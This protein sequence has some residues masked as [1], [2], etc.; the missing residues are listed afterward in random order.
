MLWLV[1]NKSDITLVMIKS[2]EF[3]LKNFC[4]PNINWKNFRRCFISYI[5]IKKERKKKTDKDTCH[6]CHLSEEHYCLWTK[7]S[8]QEVPHFICRTSKHLSQV[9]VVSSFCTFCTVYLLSQR[10]G[11]RL[12]QPE[13]KNEVNRVCV[14]AKY[15][16][17]FELFI[18]PKG[19]K[20][21]P[22][23][24]VTWRFKRES[25]CQRKQRDRVQNRV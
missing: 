1:S 13:Y 24:A 18:R 21:W 2:W 23:K 10:E 8:K 22:K 11:E 16:I 6:C 20:S 3:F 19:Q 5:F 25:L 9:V 17:Y 4:V 12:H 15:M 7:L 14:P